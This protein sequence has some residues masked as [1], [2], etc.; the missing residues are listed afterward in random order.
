MIVR[1]WYLRDIELKLVKSCRLLLKDQSPRV[2]MDT[3]GLV[4]INILLLPFLKRGI[5]Y[6]N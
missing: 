5:I 2:S 6:E 4:I 3:R 1:G